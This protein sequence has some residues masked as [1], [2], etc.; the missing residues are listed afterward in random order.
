MSLLYMK[1]DADNSTP[2]KSH[3]DVREPDLNKNRP[4]D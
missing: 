2:S 3:Y 4:K 1:A